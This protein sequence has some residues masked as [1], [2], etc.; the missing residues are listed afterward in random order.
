MRHFKLEKKIM[1]IDKDIQA[2]TV[3]KRYL[4]NVD[5]IEDIKTTL[6]KERQQYVEELYSEDTASRYGCVEIIEPLLNKELSHQEQL[7]LL[8]DIKEIFGRRFPEVSKESHGLN[9]WLKALNVTCEWTQNNDSDW[10]TLVMT[11]II[12]KKAN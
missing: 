9:A 1:K 2:L 3:A 12:P 5:E 10:A 6:N 7:S 4:S 8:E 11:A